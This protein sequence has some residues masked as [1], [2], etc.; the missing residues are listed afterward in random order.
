MQHL[1]QRSSMRTFSVLSLLPLTNSRL[2]DDHAT[3]YTGPT[4]ARS[5]ATKV[6]FMPSQSL[7]ALSKDALTTHLPSGENWTWAQTASAL[8]AC[9]ACEASCHLCCLTDAYL[10]MGA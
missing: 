9:V 8:Y 7:I 4:C 10:H 5:V 1:V 3:W 6:P 2:S